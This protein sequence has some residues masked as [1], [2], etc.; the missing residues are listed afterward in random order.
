MIVALQAN[1]SFAKL[2]HTT[3]QQG[4][5]HVPEIAAELGLTIT[6]CDY[7]SRERR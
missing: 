2:A 7:W 3:K 1:A 5:E 4:L 6:L